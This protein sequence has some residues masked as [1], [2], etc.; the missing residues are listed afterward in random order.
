MS[1]S[2][3]TIVLFHPHMP[4]TAAERMTE[5]LATRWIGQGPKVDLFEKR[6]SERFAGGQTSVAVG[7]GTDALHLAYVLAGIRDGDEVVTPVFT[8]TA[9]NIPLLYERATPVFADVQ[10][11]TLNIDP[12]HVKTLVTERT[13]AII[14]VHYGG[15]P[16]DMDGLRA[17][18]DQW[19]IPVIE[20]AAHAVGAT[21]HGKMI[22]EISEFTMFSFQAI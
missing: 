15:L 13:K 21:Y 22:G 3:K 14:C 17:V 8:C 11:H 19:G 10:P 16:C 6:F 4:K 18:A 20:D 1:T 7:S 12:E 5:T 2:E 9:T